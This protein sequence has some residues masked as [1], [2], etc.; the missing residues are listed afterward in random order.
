MIHGP[1][2]TEELARRALALRAETGAQWKDIAAELGVTT[3]WIR[4]HASKFGDVCGPL[5]ATPENIQT[6]IALRAA[7]VCWKSIARQLNL[8]HWH[9]LRR[10]VA[11]T[12]GEIE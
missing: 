9:W 2:K 10:V 12:Q 11:R 8:D 5:V 1:R 4:R 6:A 7:G 3:D